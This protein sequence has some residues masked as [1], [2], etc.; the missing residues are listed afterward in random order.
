MVRQRTCASRQ[1]FQ[2]T[3][4]QG[5]RAYRGRN[6]EI[7][8]FTQ[9]VSSC[10]TYWGAGFGTRRAEHQHKPQ[11]H[12]AVPEPPAAGR[13]RVGRR[14]QLRLLRDVRRAGAAGALFFPSACPLFPFDALGRDTRCLIQLCT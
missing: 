5:A 4:L 13:H 11:N 8:V 10:T 14:R 2:V 7:T 9:L 1:L 6:A 12:V 3:S